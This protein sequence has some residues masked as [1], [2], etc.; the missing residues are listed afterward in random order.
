MFQAW[1]HSGAMALFWSIKYHCQKTLLEAHHGLLEFCMF[2][3]IWCLVISSIFCFCLSTPHH[4]LAGR[5]ITHQKTFYFAERP[6]K[7][8][9]KVTA[10]VVWTWRWRAGSNSCC[11]AY[12]WL[13][14]RHHD[15]ILLMAL[16]IFLPLYPKIKWLQVLAYISPG[17]HLCWENTLPMWATKKTI[18]LSIILVGS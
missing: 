2:C 3:Q 6:P 12:L 13:Y 5:S 17:I 10:C 1:V 11:V 8:V 18:L 16:C 9:A 14:S 7:A 4:G 15:D